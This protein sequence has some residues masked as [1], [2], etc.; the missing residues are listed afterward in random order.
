MAL[1]DPFGVDVP[2][3]FDITHTH[4]LACVT[5]IIKTNFVLSAKYSMTVVLKKYW[6]PSCDL[7]SPI[8]GMRLAKNLTIAEIGDLCQN[9]EVL[10]NHV[11][12]NVKVKVNSFRP[13]TSG[14]LQLSAVSVSSR[15]PCVV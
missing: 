14:L 2:L 3:N 9:L 11:I 13:D 4:S 7:K 15:A 12:T 6:S 5:I 10:E 1:Y 8:S